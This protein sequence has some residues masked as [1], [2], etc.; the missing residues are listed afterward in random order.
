MTSFSWFLKSFQNRFTYSSKKVNKEDAN[1]KSA[2]G[3]QPTD[4][5]LKAQMRIILEGEDFENDPPKPSK[6]RYW[7]LIKAICRGYPDSYASDLLCL[8]WV[9]NHPFL[10]S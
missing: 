7:H 5:E 9:T 4:D 10:N 8:F 1:A 6:V 3:S 2:Q